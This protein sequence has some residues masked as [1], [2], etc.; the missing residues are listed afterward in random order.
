MRA[1]L[2]SLFVAVVAACQS[3]PPKTPPPPDP[4]ADTGPG[5]PAAAPPR[6]DPS[7]PPRNAFFGNPDRISPQL[8]PDGKH[9]A[10]LAPVEGVMN[11]WVGPAGDPSKAKPVTQ[12][13]KRG[14]RQYFWTYATDQLVY[15]QD[16]GGNENFHLYGVDVQKGTTVDLT[17]VAGVRA[18]VIGLSHKVPDKLLVGLNDRDPRFHDVYEIEIKNAKR[19]LVF[20]NEQGYQPASDLD[21][22]VRVATK[23]LPD[24]S[25]DLV[26]IGKDGKA[27]PL[28]KIPAEDALATA[29]MG[30]DK[31]GKILRMSDT[32]GRDKSALV[33][34]DI[35]KGTLS[36]V[37]EPQKA[38]LSGVLVHPTEKTVQAVASTF[39]R[40]EWTLLDKSLE[41]DF[42]ALGKADRG[43]IQILSRTLD[44]KAWVV[45]YARDDG[46]VRYHLYDRK[47]KKTTF[48]FTASSALEK[49]K[50]A[51]MHPVVVPSRD[52][53]S[54]VSYLTLP[55]AADPDGD[56]KPDKALPMV[57]VVHGGPW[58]RDGW[59]YNPVH[60][61]LASRGYAVLSTNYRG[62]TGFGKKF[63]NLADKEWAGKMHDDLIDATA[64]AAK[65][66][67]AKRDK[68]AIFGGSYGG[69]SALVGLTFTPESFTCAVDIVGPSN[70]VTLLEN[71]P[72]Y[73]APFYPM[74]S[75]KIADPKTAEGK[76]WLTSR[77]PLSR[78]DKIQR[79]LL[80]GQGAN[81]PRVKQLESDQIVNAM[82]A[83]T[84]P[85]TYVLYP[86]EGHGFV[87]PENRKSFNAVAEAF[88]AQCLGG[89]YEPVG[90]D[91][92]GASITVPEGAEHVVGL[93]EALAGKKP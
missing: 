57:L 7:L 49:L 82:Q 50:L 22:K 15:L 24:A 29:V 78:V 4:P 6:A 23:M 21:L 14:L 34:M 43:D 86:D 38:D 80:I 52:G 53:L 40:M 13:T 60:Q 37:H 31:T 30:F 51:R 3:D 73:W 70:L 44:D 17:P 89:P 18:Q 1:A 48:L 20:K 68:I 26:S 90:S 88:L 74:L 87:R 55:A 91:F 85:V 75:N 58:A 76:A 56:G 64:W 25:V 54:L 39:E 92:S 8:S 79:P 61:W 93:K 83:R 35:A 59:G 5:T 69:Y 65:S 62:S 11:V 32:R 12:E 27:A 72:P 16:E 33:E 81:D 19:K 46:P 9:L 77:S 47:A 71:I 84:I 66:G 36:V 63:V 28:A 41:A 2:A 67:V 45:A 10:F 42:A